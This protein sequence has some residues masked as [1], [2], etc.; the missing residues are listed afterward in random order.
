MPPRG[1]MLSCPASTCILQ[2]VGVLT[3]EKGALKQS[4]GIPAQKDMAMYKQYP[5]WGMRRCSTLTLECT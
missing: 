2:H 4:Q 1:T 3:H 5:G